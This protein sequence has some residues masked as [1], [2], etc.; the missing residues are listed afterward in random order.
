MNSSVLVTRSEPGASETARRL[1]ALGYD[2]VAEP[3]LMLEPIAADVPE[4]DALAFTS[5]NGVRRF[6]ELCGRRDAPVW[7]VGDR[8]AAEARSTGFSDVRSAAGDVTALIDLL[9]SELPADNH[10][11]HTGNEDAGDL[12][13]ESIRN[14]GGTATFLPTYRTSTAEAPGPR[15]AACLGG[16]AALDCILVYSPKAGRALARL[17]E[18]A[19]LANLGGIACISPN[20]ASPL[21][22][23]GV[24]IDTASAPDEAGLFRSMESVVG[25]Q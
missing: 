14:A 18:R 4:F 6:S 25:R 17:L 24:P 19:S 11:L 22:R 23:L 20:A 8:T 15:L 21:E 9:R 13:V 12:L 2:A 1:I 7:C 3:L 10:L 16:T 5:V